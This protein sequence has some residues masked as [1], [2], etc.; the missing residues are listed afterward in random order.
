[1]NINVQIVFQGAGDFVVRSEVM[2]GE[3]VVKE[4]R[5]EIMDIHQE[6]SCECTGEQI[7]DVPVKVPK[8]ILE[9]ILDLPQ[10]R[11]SERTGEQIVGVPVKEILAGMRHALLR[12][13]FVLFPSV[14]H[15]SP[16]D[17]RA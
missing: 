9:G 16:C 11:I 14:G 17:A 3:A 7:A 6:R 2:E 13:H 5:E 1:M 10:E 8:E 12:R 15:V 4:I